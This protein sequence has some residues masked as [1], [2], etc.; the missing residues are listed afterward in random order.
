MTPD[1]IENLFTRQGA[2]RFA[3]WG[4]PI[5]PVV[6]GVED[7]TLSVVKGAL[8]AVTTFAGHA[9]AETDPELGANLMIFF[10]RDWMEL[11]E[12]PNLDR[13]IPDIGKIAAR[14]A[15]A[16][17]VQ[18]RT[19]RFDEAGGIKAAFAFI[20]MGGGME[21]LPAETVAM[22]QAAQIMLTWGDGAFAEVS[23]L[24]KHPDNG[25]VMLRPEIAGLIRAAYDPVMPVAAN[26]AA[27]ALR[28]S[29]RMQG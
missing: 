24:A 1:E 20:R 15:K 21:K 26:D 27:H 19:F 22:M 11:A 9:M 29:A 12:V 18:Y 2:Y 28:L 25:M 5:A 14:L 6:F 3:R 13:M 16:E 7:A 10:F 23:P 8:E 4:R 17:A